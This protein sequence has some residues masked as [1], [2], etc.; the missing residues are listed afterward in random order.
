MV[1]AEGGAVLCGDPQC[2]VPLRPSPSMIGLQGADGLQ[3]FMLVAE[4]AIYAFSKCRR[5]LMTVNILN[6]ML[7]HSAV[8][9]HRPCVQECNRLFGT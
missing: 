2:E 7:G 8:R 6:F 3:F 4:V 9:R 5:S 1:L